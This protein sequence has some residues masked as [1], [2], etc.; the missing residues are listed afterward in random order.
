MNSYSPS[1]PQRQVKDIFLNT[2]FSKDMAK[3]FHL[4]GKMRTH[5]RQQPL[6][7][8]VSLITA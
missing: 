3:T 5:N 4:Q 1:L 7:T 2:W 6:S 8:A